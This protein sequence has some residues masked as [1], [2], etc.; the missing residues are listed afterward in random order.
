MSFKRVVVL[1]VM[2]AAAALGSEALLQAERNAGQPGRQAPQQ[3]MAA[4]VMPVPV[5]R[6]I[7]RAAPVTL[8]YVAATEAIRKVSLQAKAT[9][10]L[11]QQ[12]AADGA[13]VEKDAL[14]YKIDPREYQAALDQARAQQQR[15]AAA[16]SY[17]HVTFNRNATLNKNGWASKDTF[18]QTHSAWRQSEAALAAD[19]AA[20]E[21]AE[22]NLAYTEIRAPFAGRLSR[23]A[24]NEGALIT[25]AGAP[26]NTLVQLDPIY[27]TFNPAEIDIPEIQKY[28]AQRAVPADIMLAGQTEPSYRGELSFLDNSV[29]RGT[30]TITARA[31]AANPEKKLLPGQFVRVR[32]HLGEQPGALFAPQAALGSA[33]TGKFLYV[34]GKDSKVEQRFV[35]LGAVHGELVAVSGAIQEGELVITGNLQKI[36]P[37]AVVQPL[38]SEENG[39]RSPPPGG[40]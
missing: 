24:L 12:A 20:I 31:T 34:V 4:F 30:G 38:L 14:L 3:A 6:V 10:Y 29:D 17:A 19:K 16:S 25:V 8:E 5:T 40:S 26:L 15:D 11:L 18:D 21:A 13:D 9:G 39:Q 33:Q 22:L 36:G 35:T 7:K 23:S 37:G 27:V 28:A 1:G 32:L 2:V